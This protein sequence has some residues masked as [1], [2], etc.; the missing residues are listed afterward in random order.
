[1][2]TITFRFRHSRSDDLP[3][4]L[5]LARRGAFKEFQ[6][7]QKLRVYE[8]TFDLLDPIALGYALSL[9][10]ALV[11]D[12]KAEVFSGFSS[13]HMCTVRAVLQ[14]YQ[15]SLH[16]DD[17][18]VHCWFRASY[19]RRAPTL[20]EVTL[21]DHGDFWFPCRM[22]IQAAYGIHPD[23]RGTIPDQIEAALVRAETHWCPR[24]ADRTETRALNV[25]LEKEPS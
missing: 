1:M 15:Q 14:C 2:A 17:P 7:G 12:K 8:T 9:A 16:A 13:L 5:E 20:Y 3:W 6:L 4:F 21:G 22:A 23:Q 18:A 24:L 11:H 25:T 19:S 10:T